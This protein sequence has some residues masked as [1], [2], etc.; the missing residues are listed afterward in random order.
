MQFWESPMRSKFIASAAA[1]GFALSAG[2]ASAVAVNVQSF[3]TGPG[4]VAGAIAAQNLFHATAVHQIAFEDF[5]G[6][7]LNQVDDGAAFYQ[8]ALEPIETAVG[9]FSSVGGTGSG[10]TVV[11]DPEKLAVRDGSGTAGLRF[12]TS[13]G[14]G[15]S[16]YLDSND[17]NGIS[18]ELPGSAT[19][20]PAYFDQL[21]FMTTDIDDVGSVTFE[22][23]IGG[24]G[25]VFSVSDFFGTTARPNGE[26]LLFTILFDTLVSTADFALNIDAGDGFG[27]DSIRITATPLPA[28]AWLLIGG[29]AGLYGMRRFATKAA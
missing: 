4:G 12:N 13:G 27:I 23:V 1:L 28:A 20:S 24:F 10:S 9:D 21:S 22:L 2:S 26:L 11:G 25:T 5:E 29:V 18:W 3:G 7:T 14:A 6:I 15:D 19:F 16:Q 8:A 17:T